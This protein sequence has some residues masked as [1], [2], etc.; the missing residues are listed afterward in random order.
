MNSNTNITECPFLHTVQRD[1]LNLER[2]RIC[3][4]TLSPQNVYACLVCGRFFSGRG[5]Q[6]E[7]F[8]HSVQALHHIFMNLQDGTFWCLPD[9]YEVKDSS[10]LDIR[11]ALNPQFTDK[12][13]QDLNSSTKLSVDVHGGTFLPG[14]IGMNNLGKTDYISTI[15]LSLAHVKPLRDFFLRPE[16]YSQCA[17][18][19]G[20]SKEQLLVHH[21]G[22]LLRRLWFPRAL[23]ATVS[24]HIF[25]N[26]VSECS[27]HRY[28][29]AGKA[30]EAG[31]FL[32]WL[33]NS[34]HMG[35]TTGPQHEQT[36]T[37]ES[38]KRG[39]PSDSDEKYKESIITELFQGELEV[40]LISS[41]LEDERLIE[42]AKKRAE[43]EALSREVEKKWSDV[44]DAKKETVASLALGLRLPRTSRMPFRFLSLELP[45]SPLFNDAKGSVTI[46]QIPV[47]ALLSKYDG[48]TISESLRGQ[49][50]ERKSFKIIK[51]PRYLLFSIKRFS[52]NA[53]FMDKNPTIVSFP[54]S[55]LELKP[56]T[57][58]GSSKDTLSTKYDLLSNV[59]HVTPPYAVAGTSSLKD[60]KKGIATRL[61]SST[62]S[63]DSSVTA[64]EKKNLAS[65]SDSIVTDPLARGY[66]KVHL[67]RNEQTWYEVQDLS[68]TEILPQQI[69]VSES[70]IVCFERN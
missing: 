11:D 9:G 46:P 70:L 27:R 1:C 12:E 49:Y 16:N 2:Q 37:N 29:V 62:S 7:A 45:P 63:K 40:T 22:D 15:V 43:A 65:S 54:I 51:L 17:L 10:L 64:D 8:T 26:V 55:N 48:T 68:V 52:R 60:S 41:D 56:F 25:I 34:L 50:R 59:C 20:M 35:L 28:G 14:F 4:V 61:V 13:I 31:E 69:G 39:R 58:E 42:V 19:S 6:T 18:S 21:F 24:P 57:T 30:V 23:K 36:Q 33:L 3:S 47:Y 38:G 5:K 67:R 53:F 32:A 66:Y 44:L